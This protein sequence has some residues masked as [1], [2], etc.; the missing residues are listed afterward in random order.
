MAC[1]Q[2]QK[3]V[4]IASGEIAVLSDK[5]GE[6]S[7]LGDLLVARGR[8]TEEQLAAAL[9]T[10]RESE[11]R[12]RLGDLLIKLG[13]IKPD[14]I[15][16]SLKFQLEEEICD[17]F[18]WKN[19]TFE[20]DGERSIE[21]ACE[22]ELA[23]S[24][25]QRLAIEPQAI[26]AEAS[27][28]MAEWKT[29][30]ARLPTP[31]LCFKLTPKGEELGPKANPAT[32]QLVKLLQE[33]RTIETTVKR[34]C[35]GRF[36]V[37]RTIIKL[38]D[39]G[40]VF[41]YPASELQRLASEHRAHRRFPD[42]LFIYRR[43]IEVAPS[44]LE[45]RE[46]QSL[47]ND[48]TEAIR[49][50]QEAGELVE[51]AETVSFKDAAARYRRRQ[52]L[53]RAA[54]LLLLGGALIGATL[55]L[56]EAYR[57]SDRL[58]EDYQEAMKT[59]A[60]AVARNR[61]DEAARI[62]QEFYHKLPN[63]QGLTAKL[64]LE[65]LEKLPLMSNTFVE[66]ALQPVEAQEN[67][68]R[69]DEAEAAYR[70][71]LKRYAG[72]AHAK[73]IE[74]GLERIAAKRRALEEKRRLAD[75]QARLAAAKALLRE[76]RFTTARTALQQ[77]A[78]GAAPGSPE[79]QEVE[80]ELKMLRDLEAQVQAGIQAAEDALREQKGEQ[81]IA[82]YE[83]AVGIWPDLPAAD[84]A[85]KQSQLLKTRLQ[86]AGQELRGAETLAT[87]GAILEALDNLR[88]IQKEYAEFE[89]RQKAAE[90]IAALTRTVDALT[91]RIAQAREV[92]ARDKTQGRR[93]FAALMQEQ[94]A[95]L[96]RRQVEVPVLIA[97]HPA[98]ATVTIDDLAAGLAPLEVPLRCGKSFTL[99]LAK[100]GY[101]PG[102][103]KITRLA[104][105]DLLE[106]HVTLNREALRILE[107]K[108]AILA[109][110]VVLDQHLYVAHGTSL[111]ALDVL[112]TVQA[113]SLPK[114]LD[115]TPQTRPNSDGAG[116]P[117]FVN[118]RSWW[119]LRTPPEPAG[120]GKLL[121]PLR[122][123]E[124]VEIDVPSRSIR[125]LITLPV[126]PVGRPHLERTSLLAGKTL[127]AVGCADGKVRAYDLAKPAA[128]VWERP[129]DPA[130]PAPKGALA[131]GLA[132]CTRP[133]AF[134]A[135]SASGRLTRFNI[136]NGQE[137]WAM[138]LKSALA[139]TA[140]LPATP[141]EDLAALVCA[142][143][144]VIVVDVSRHEQVWELPV[145]QAMD[146]A[147][148]AVVAGDG[149]YVISRQGVVCRFRRGRQAG[150]P[151]PLWRKPLDG[152]TEV[153]LCAGRNLYVV[154]T[155]G[156]IYA[157]AAGDGHE[158]WKYR[159]QGVPTH[160]VEIGGVLYVTTKEGRMVVLN[161]E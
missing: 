120:P 66:Q 105:E 116:A 5:L 93:L 50:A 37:C 123:R 161:T 53:K 69:L 90:R 155:F 68:G 56:A 118:D 134:L 107:F 36:N 78:D 15:A 11:Q 70:A 144:R 113:W 114:L 98:G 80:G 33:G 45:R 101:E 127:I 52:V 104:P 106:I 2:G 151:V 158:L 23:G 83:T 85:R 30:E 152:G 110:P 100:Q 79:R 143:G 71:L 136:V 10:Q 121:L 77:L 128:P 86:Q 147:S 57:P 47:I 133:G 153:P 142:D 28:R 4:A 97:S 139:P 159:V 81:A 48:T 145:A 7:R 108:P 41:P 49:K 58:A 35:A 18:T 26:I 59:A 16:A 64:V 132:A 73:R 160:L 43:L 31:Y 46:L 95:F 138:D 109:P 92:Y 124:I 40:W 27:R 84:A 60:E 140:S 125:K 20:F 51:G 154:S 3:I 72:S 75:L 65:Q 117:Q 111:T 119:Y 150:Q 74:D 122:S 67:A 32:Q 76:K 14:D 63:K 9:K 126:E 21:E 62:W 61:Y 156:T 149:T 82:Y 87:E 115:D 54:A 1:A 34:S 29:I 38:L 89:V 129:A 102:E 135:L 8:L 24:H 131:T 6:R 19:A 148:H 112:A 91:T 157:L 17:L 39:E 22:D 88:R 99:H 55:Y 42:A 130:T 141:L 137:D 44:D 94:P 96:A 103:Q 146:E 12:T 25:L 13:I